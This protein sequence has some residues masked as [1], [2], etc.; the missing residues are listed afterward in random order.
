MYH[1]V[2]LRSRCVTFLPL[3]VSKTLHFSY[4]TTNNVHFATQCAIPQHGVILHHASNINLIFQ[5]WI[6]KSY[7]SSSQYS[8]NYKVQHLLCIIFV[9][10]LRKAEILSINLL[11]TYV[12]LQIYNCHFLHWWCLFYVAEIFSC[13]Y[14]RYTRLVHRRVLFILLCVVHIYHFRPFLSSLI[15]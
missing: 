11:S 5:K 10:T 2:W 8:L 7:T 15:C 12:R 13:Y 9:Y 14:Y 4:I 6:R 3:V 1:S